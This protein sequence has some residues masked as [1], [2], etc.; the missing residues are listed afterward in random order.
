MEQALTEQIT[1]AT[2]LAQL[3]AS[4]FKTADFLRNQ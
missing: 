3:K 2:L 1:D 4:F